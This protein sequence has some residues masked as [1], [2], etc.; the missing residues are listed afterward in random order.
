MIGADPFDSPSF[1]GLPV[2]LSAASLRTGQDNWQLPAAV[3]GTGIPEIPARWLDIRPHEIPLI[4]M[5]S[6]LLNRLIIHV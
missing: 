5:L 6:P 2:K 3:V 1:F 4:T